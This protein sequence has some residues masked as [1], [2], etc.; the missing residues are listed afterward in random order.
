MRTSRY[1]RTDER[2]ELIDTLEHTRLLSEL[3]MTDARRWKWFLVLLHNALQGACVCALRGADTSG[4][5][6][7][8]NDVA[9][10]VHRWHE[11]D[12]QGQQSEPYPEEKLESMLELF[13]RIKKDSYLPEAARYISDAQT[14]RDIRKLNALRNTFIHFTPMGLSLE[15]IGLPRIAHNAY[16]VIDHLAVQH[17]TFWYQLSGRKQR[18]IRL[19]V[20]STTTNLITLSQRAPYEPVNPSGV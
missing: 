15:L 19:A 4:I 20:K 9:R 8:Q 13:R 11:R 7:L 6:V 3:I 5:S 1:L 10:K 16:K 17:P 12:R 14:D 2:E 18:R